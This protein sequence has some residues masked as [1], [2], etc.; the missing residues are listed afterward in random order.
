MSFRGCPLACAPD[1]YCRAYY[2]ALSDGGPERSSEYDGNKNAMIVIDEE[3]NNLEFLKKWYSRT[4]T[5]TAPARGV[6][7]S[8][9]YGSDN[10]LIHT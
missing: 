4:R 10:W 5:R 6:L 7:A 9:V 3:I 8:C 1:R 2:L